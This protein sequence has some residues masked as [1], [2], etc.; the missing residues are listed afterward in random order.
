MTGIAISKPP[1][2]ARMPAV[3]LAILVRHHAHQLIAAHFRLERTA[4]AAI[5][6]GG[7]DRMFR[8]TDFDHRFFL[9]RCRRAGLNT[10]TT[11]HAF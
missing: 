1:L 10:G 9:K 8:L 11:R 3:G 7:D 6:A 4:D 5:G 2:N